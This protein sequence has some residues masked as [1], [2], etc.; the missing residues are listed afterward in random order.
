MYGGDGG[1][2]SGSDDV[3]QAAAEINEGYAVM[4]IYMV[5]VV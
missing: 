4:R 1:T 2:G 3:W 5:G